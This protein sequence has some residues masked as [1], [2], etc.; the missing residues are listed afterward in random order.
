MP[1]SLKSEETF[2]ALSRLN[3]TLLSARI[4]VA[5]DRLQLC[6][7]RRPN[8]RNEASRYARRLAVLSLARSAARSK[9]PS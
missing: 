7:M 6:D 5:T 4:S 8:G 2:L 9:V 1:L 3:D